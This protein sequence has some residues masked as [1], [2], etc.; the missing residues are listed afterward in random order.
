L[1]HIEGVTAGVLFNNEQKSEHFALPVQALRRNGI[2]RFAQHLVTH[3]LL[4]KNKCMVNVK[5]LMG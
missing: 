3:L 1:I 4:C 2:L 5:G